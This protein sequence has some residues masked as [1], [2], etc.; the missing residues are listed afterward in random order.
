MMI[1]ISP[2]PQGRVHDLCN[3]FIVL[4]YSNK[5]IMYNNPATTTTIITEL[6]VCEREKPA[7]F[8]LMY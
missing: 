7:R 5:I 3:K 1:F 4:N 6:T 2:S 8:V